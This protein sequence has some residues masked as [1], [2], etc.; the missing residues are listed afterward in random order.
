M[1]EYQAYTRRQFIQHG[2]VMVSTAT[3]IPGF[4]ASS[5]NL[6][7]AQ[8][9]GSQTSSLPGVPEDRVLVVIQLSGGNDGLNTLIPFGRSEYYA[10]RPS[11]AVKENDV[12]ALDQGEGIGLHPQM[13]G[14]YEM[15]G[16]GLATVVPGVGYPNPNRSHFAS[17]DVWHTGDTRGG[18]GVGWIG[19]ALDKH[20][21]DRS[22]GR[23]N[24]DD[25]LACVTIGNNAPPAANGKIVKPIVFENAQLF[26]W[27]GRDLHADI[28]RSYDQIQRREVQGNG[29]ELDFVFRTSMDAQIASDQV[30]KAVGQKT[31]VKFPG[32]S[33]GKQLQSVAAMIRA[34]LPTRVYYVAMGGFDTHANQAG[35]HQNLLRDFSQ[36]TRAF[37]KDLEASGHKSRVVTMAFSEFGRRVRQNASG[38]TDHGTAG[39][40]FVFGD[41][42][43][44]IPG[45]R[46]VYPSLTDLDSG[47]LKFNLDF[48]CVYADLLSNWM[49]LDSHAA[50]GKKFM[51][52]A[53]IR[54]K[55][56]Q[57]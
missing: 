36:A 26:R 8:G 49:K 55:I 12:L 9:A 17:M 52:T 57:G 46:G 43:N 20:V 1:N 32:S 4:L 35:R 23:L 34:E 51:Q 33:L 38:G 14:I 2:V 42:K 40:L 44:I 15:V 7:A 37:Y 28:E 39:T 24:S 22:G 6:L 25:A 3:T 45:L 54:R 50:L 11:I 48:R 31:A 10:A 27:S 29:S 18:K 13:R 30:R 41:Q 21:Q 19:K 56:A 53:I 16:E 47:D 5:G